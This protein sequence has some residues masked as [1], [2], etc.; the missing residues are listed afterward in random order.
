MYVVVQVKKR[1]NKEGKQKGIE[2]W[3]KMIVE[4][5]ERIHIM[6]ITMFNEYVGESQQLVKTGREENTCHS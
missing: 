2:R 4:G 6:C 5:I 3:S 1:R